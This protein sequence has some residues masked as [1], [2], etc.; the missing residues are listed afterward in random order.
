MVY[1]LSIGNYNKIYTLYTFVTVFKY[2]T[3]NIIYFSRRKV[4]WDYSR[5]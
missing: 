2:C 4:P 3:T 5:Y 1:L